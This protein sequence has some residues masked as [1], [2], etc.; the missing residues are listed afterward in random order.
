[1]TTTTA[2]RKAR[3]TFD[4]WALLQSGAI[5][6][7]TFERARL[8]CEAVRGVC[9][10]VERRFYMRGP[11]GTH[12]LLCLATDL[13]RLNAHWTIFATDGRNRCS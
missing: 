12:S 5:S 11:S 6:S 10:D 1:M 2:Q 9:G 13:D 8:T 7:I 3:V 4:Q